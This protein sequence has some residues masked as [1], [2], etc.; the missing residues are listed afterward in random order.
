MKAQLKIKKIIAI[1]LCKFDHGFSFKHMS[2]R[3]DVRASTIG[4]RY[5]CDVFCD[6]QNS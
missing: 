2:N 6:R 1:V 5:S 4:H 3:F